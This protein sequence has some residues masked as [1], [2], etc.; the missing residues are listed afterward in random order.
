MKDI[1]NKIFEA[2]QSLVSEVQNEYDKDY[3]YQTFVY[4]N[5]QKKYDYGFLVFD[6][7]REFYSIT[8]FNEDSERGEEFAT[9]YDRDLEELEELE[10]GDSLEDHTHGDNYIYI[11]TRIW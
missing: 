6:C 2:K 7:E 11:I 8:A 1:T 5:G 3:A 4:D 9:E 10:I